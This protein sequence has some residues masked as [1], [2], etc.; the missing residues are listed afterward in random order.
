MCVTEESGLEKL[1]QLRNKGHIIFY[2]QIFTSL[3]ELI[4]FKQSQNE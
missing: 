2:V 3:E 1:D 4:S